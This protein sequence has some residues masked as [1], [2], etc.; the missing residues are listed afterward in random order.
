MRQKI[1]LKDSVAKVFACGRKADGTPYR[2]GVI[3]VPSFYRDMAAD[4]RG[5]PDFKSAT[6][7]VANLLTDFRR[8]NVDAVILDLRYNG[9]GSLPEAISLTGLFTGAGPIVQVKDAGGRVQ[10]LDDEGPGVVWPG[11]LVV[12]DQ[13]V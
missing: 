5:A 3:D 9:G 4:R 13:Q 11:P 1:A 6:R 12:L 7:D 10:H 8:Q 2:V